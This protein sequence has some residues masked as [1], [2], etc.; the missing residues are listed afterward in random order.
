MVWVIA[1]AVCNNAQIV[2]G[3]LLGQ[4]TEGAIL[5]AAIKVSVL[6]TYRIVRWDSHHPVSDGPVSCQ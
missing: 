3:N 1:G 5:A 4:P 2:G 6:L